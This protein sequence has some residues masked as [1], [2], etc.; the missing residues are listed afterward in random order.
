MKPRVALYGFPHRLCP[1]R[2]LRHHFSFH[3]C[4]F[5][6]NER[7]SHALRALRSVLFLASLSFVV[8]LCKTGIY[9]DSQ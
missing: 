1:F 3:N 6:T 8:H 9:D 2:F 4:E 5:P 7:V